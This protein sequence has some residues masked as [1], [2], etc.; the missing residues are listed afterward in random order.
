MNEYP[1]DAEAAPQSI[2]LL[3]DKR[4][5]R[6]GYAKLLSL[7]GQNA[8]VYGLFIAVISKQ[9]SSLATSAFVLASVVPSIVLSL[10]GGL[11]SDLMPNKFALLSTMVVRLLI[12]FLFFQND[13]SVGTVIGLTF[14]VWTVYQFFSPAENAAV[15]AIVARE[16]LAQASSILQAT[17]LVAQLLGAGMVAPVA[18]K[19]LGS[20]GL[21]VIVFV[22]LALSGLLYAMV[23]DLTAEQE[24]EAQRLSPWRS[25]PVGFRTIA[26]DRGMRTVTLLRILLDTGMLAFV[27]VAPVFVEKTLHSG[28]ENVIYIAIPG[29]VGLALGLLLAPP[30]LTFISPRHLAM[31]GFV[32]FVAILLT[33]PFVDSLAPQLTQQLGP[34]GDLQRAVHLSDTLVATMLL[35][36]IAGLGS[37]FVQ[38]AART[39]VYRRSPPSVIA[40]VFSTQSA[41]GSVAALAP[42]FLTGVLLDALPVRVVL[43]IIGASLVGVALTIWLR[44]ARRTERPVAT[45]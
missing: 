26:A 33:L 7:I 43:L 11:F 37:S 10:P 24:R 29:A 38:V 44:G 6:Y 36:P 1:P 41:L 17:S 22:L 42:T 30:I 45:Y 34:F 4:F 14:L 35:L 25:L 3:G 28:A 39:E 18:V 31:A 13:S 9:H 5:V 23:P 21:Y 15:L 20:D 27:V 8:L 2:G 12:V 32:L 16:R 19:Y 40:Q